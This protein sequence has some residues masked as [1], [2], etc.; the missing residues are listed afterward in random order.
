MARQRALRTPSPSSRTQPDDPAA[1]RRRPSPPSGPWTPLGASAG[2]IVLSGLLAYANSL[3]NPFILDDVVA[4]VDNPHIREWWNAESVLFPRRELPTAGRPL[5]NFSF[6]VNYALGGLNPVGY[7][8]VNIAF[9][10]LSG[11]LVFGIVRRTLQ[12][13]ALKDCFVFRLKPEATRETTALNLGFAAGLLW[14]LHPLN[15]EAVNYVTQRTELMMAFFYLLTLYASIRATLSS[16]RAWSSTAVVSCVAGMACKESMVTAPVVVMLYDI[17]FVFGSAKKAF[18]ERRHFYA[19]LCLSWVVLAAL[20][21]PG[22]RIR[23][24]GFS[25]DV[26]PWTYLLNQAVMICQYLQLAVWPR[27]LVANYGWPVPLTLGDVLPHALLVATLLAVTTVMLVR[28]PKW[29]FLGA[30]FFITLAPTSSIVPIATEVGAERRMYLPLIAL[31]VLAVV[32]AAFFMAGPKGPALRRV[33]PAVGFALAAT[34]FAIGVFA[35]NREYA[36]PVLLARTIVERHPTSTAHH[37]L[38]VELLIAGDRDAAMGELRRAVPGAPRAH[39]TLGVELVKDGRTND[40]IEQFQAFLQKQPNL[41]EAIPARQLLGRALAQQQRW[42]EA[43]E[44]EQQVLTMNP[45]EAQRLDTHALLAEAYFGVEN[46]QETIAHCL[47]YLRARPNDGRVLT[48]LGI[49]FIA[50]DRLEDAIA[51]F[52]RAAAAEPAD[53]DAQLNLASALDDHKDFQEALGHAQRALALRPANAQTHHLVGRLLAQLGRFEEARTHL[54]RALQID[55][56][57]VDAKED[58]GRL[59]AV[60]GR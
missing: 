3:S 43:I 28:Q 53:P 17:V 16:R 23:S 15:S 35:R 50:T 20:V 29:G 51:A 56:G 22:P 41:V 34:L 12:L 54:D 6:A 10:L 26:S 59:Q 33:W 52:R 37:V 5:V 57:N 13:P 31:V 40:A 44:Q 21:W 14:T 42:A 48:R 2:V 58:L 8:V 55:P 49:A 39:Y 45:S 47:E 32:S 4:I 46:F 11:L 38:G 24:A 27:A 1:I 18:R 36:S 25:T 19:A 9:H 7:H 30:W 60:T